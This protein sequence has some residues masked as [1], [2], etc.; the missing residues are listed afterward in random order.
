MSPVTDSLGPAP[1]GVLRAGDQA[2]REQAFGAVT[3]TVQQPPAV[4][5]F[6][7]SVEPHRG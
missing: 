1:P 5:T 6:L 2:L 4:G 3:R 7:V